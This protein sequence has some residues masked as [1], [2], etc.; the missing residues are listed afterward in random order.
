MCAVGC[1]ILGKSFE[2]RNMTIRPP[3]TGASRVAFSQCWQDADVLLEALQVDGTDTCLSAASA[4][5]NTLAL[6]G[7][8]ASRVIAAD[9]S[10]AQIACLELRVSAY[11]NLRHAEFLELLGQNPSR[12]RLDLYE[13]CRGELSARVRRFWDKR[14]R[15]ILQGIV[16]SGRFERFLSLLR[17]F[18]LPLVHRRRKVERLFELSTVQERHEFFEREWNTYRWTMLCNILIGNA[19]RDRQKRFANVLVELPPQKNPYLQ[20]MLAGRYVSALPYA[21][22][23]ENFDRIRQN[24]DSLEWHCAS[25]EEVIASLP[26]DILHCCNLSNIFE[27]VS[28]ESHR[29]TL[30]E[31]IRVSAPGCRL[32]YWNIIAERRCPAVLADRLRP[33]RDLALRL[34]RK[35]KAIFY[36]DLVIEEVV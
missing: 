1:S 22:R 29:Q 14:Q 33:R 20:W 11:R 12:R 36:R 24:L 30:D 25:V 4:G 21:L 7:A 10:P 18:V 26:N 2:D 13:R 6:V 28:P 9:L 3:V 35:D 34:R 17:R 19:A 8:G 5:D 27:H 32:V 16:Y 23:P 31:L 15:L